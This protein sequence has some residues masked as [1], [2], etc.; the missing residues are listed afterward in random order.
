MND[1]ATEAI[2]ASGYLMQGAT[3]L[4]SAGVSDPTVLDTRGYYNFG[5]SNAIALANADSSETMA[6]A[7]PTESAA[8]LANSGVTAG[9]TV[10]EWRASVSAKIGSAANQTVLS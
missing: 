1:P 10:G 4:Q 5:P 9:E 6:E 8:T 3:A 2:A 7:M